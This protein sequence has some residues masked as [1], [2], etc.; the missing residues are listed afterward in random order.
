M[1][2]CR[3]MAADTFVTNSFE[4]RKELFDFESLFT[5]TNLVGTEH[6][7]FSSHGAAFR[8]NA[9]SINFESAAPTCLCCSSLSALYVANLS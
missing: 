2:S 9:T 8:R 1:A 4:L 7:H 5:P 6:W 3:V